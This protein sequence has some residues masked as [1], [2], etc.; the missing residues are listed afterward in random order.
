MI[1]REMIEVIEEEIREN[2]EGSEKQVRRVRMGVRVIGKN[3]NRN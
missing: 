1:E 3:T 2:E